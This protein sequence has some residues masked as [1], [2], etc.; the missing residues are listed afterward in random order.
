MMYIWFL[1]LLILHD[2]AM[3]EDFLRIIFTIQ[4]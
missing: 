2:L 3:S 4:D 1:F